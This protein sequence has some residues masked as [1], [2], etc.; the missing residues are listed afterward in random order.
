MLLL[1]AGCAAMVAV[2]VLNPQF[3]PVSET[4]SRYVH[5]SAGWLITTA[6]LA[7]GSASAVVA[8]QV[9]R[10]P[11]GP[12]VRR[13][14]RGALAVWAGGVLVA[15]FFPADPPGR[16]SRPSMSEMVHGTAAFPAFVA[17]PLAALLLRRQLTARWPAARKALFAV[18][19][20][21]VVATAALA[22]CLIDVM[23]GPS[24]GV[25]SAPTLV[26]L[27]ERLVITVDLAWLTLAAV[28]T[29]RLSE[30]R[31]ARG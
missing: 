31:G 13:V 4:V 2:D 18:T 16:W 21:S 19:T 9:G 15:G 6:L 5:G 22:V 27:V 25:G 11:G 30:G 7:I 12:V 10:L 28:A 8:V 20:A 24:L 23:D 1:A 29:A 3:S 14:A 26:G 17:L